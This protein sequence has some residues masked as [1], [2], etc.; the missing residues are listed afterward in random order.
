M[1]EIASSH[2]KPPP[3]SLLPNRSQLSQFVYDMAEKY[4]SSNSVEEKVEHGKGLKTLLKLFSDISGHDLLESGLAE[5]VLHTAIESRYL[6][7]RSSVSA[8]H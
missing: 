6:V 8:S 7:N 3:Q 4:R 2:V 5:E 1:H